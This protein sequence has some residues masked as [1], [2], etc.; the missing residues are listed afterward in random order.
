MVVGLFVSAY[1]GRVAVADAATE[2]SA[3]GKT[4]MT[5]DFTLVATASQE[6]CFIN[7]S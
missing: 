4:D 3:A 7:S 1:R 5:E 2:K 6:K